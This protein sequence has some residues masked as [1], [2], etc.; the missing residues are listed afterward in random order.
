MLSSQEI[1]ALIA[2][3]GC[4]IGEE[5]DAQRS[6][7]HKIVIMTDADVDGSHIRTLLLT[8]FYRQM[9]G[10]IDRGFLYIAQPP[11]FKVKRGKS[12]R[13]VKDERSLE[14]YLLDLALDGASVAPDGRAGPVPPDALR[15]LLESTSAY[16]RL[17]ERLAVR[18]LDERIVDAAVWTGVPRE[19][20]LH[21]EAALRTRVAPALEARF[22][23]LAGDEAALGW[24]SEPDAEH[25]GHRLVA[26]TRRSGVLLETPLDA[27]F[28]R[29]PDFQRLVELASEASGAGA[30]PYRLVRGEAEP[31]LFPG[32]VQLL[33]RLLDLGGKGLSI[34]RYKGLG[35]MNPEQLAETTMDP[36]TRTLLQV[37]VPDAVEADEAFATLMGDEVE[38]RREFIE[39][40]ALDVQ[41]LDV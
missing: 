24:R 4:G 21:D 26:Q 27:A 8:F 15:R 39:R 1:Q 35:E 34:Q 20:E 3:I 9:K 28:V 12:E 36:A 23:A 17:L 22:R 33:E 25:G 14:R 19:A 38:P 5:F 18:R 2:A 29:S 30:P 41:N 16:R 11:L 6:R 40:N 7:Y 37:R 32:P 10:L 31:E 13:Y